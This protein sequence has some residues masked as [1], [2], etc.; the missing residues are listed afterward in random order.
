MEQA[1]LAV[2]VQN[3]LQMILRELEKEEEFESFN[4]LLIVNRIVPKLPSQSLKEMIRLL[5]P[6]LDE[7]LETPQKSINLGPVFRLLANAPVH[8]A[9]LSDFLSSSGYQPCCVWAH[10]YQLNWAIIIH[11]HPHSLPSDLSLSLSFFIL[12]PISNFSRECILFNLSL[13]LTD[14]SP[15]FSASFMCAASKFSHASTVFIS[16]RHR[17]RLESNLAPLDWLFILSLILEWVFPQNPYSWFS[18]CF[19]LD[20]WP[21]W[22]L[23]LSSSF[24]WEHI[25]GFSFLGSKFIK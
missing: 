8:D 25:C 6:I 16:S 22:L 7:N 2:R 1:R 5:R 13:S 18:W 3:K 21:L 12:R 15:I 14:S 19:S 17:S 11:N 10:S 20:F 23:V 4:D 9:L 24:R